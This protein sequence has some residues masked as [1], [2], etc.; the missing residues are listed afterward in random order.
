MIVKNN[1]PIQFVESM[2]LKCLILC[3]CPKLNFPS[4]RQFS[5]EILLGLV[6]KTNQHYVFHTL[7]DCFFTIASFDLWMSKGAYDVFALV[8]NFL[9]NDW[10]PKHVT[11]GLFEMT[12]TTSQALTRNLTQLL[13]KYGF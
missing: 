8:I 3:L 5:Q 9:N 2:W 7:V 6:Q 4:I 12:Q 11:I 13:D 10:K 1:L